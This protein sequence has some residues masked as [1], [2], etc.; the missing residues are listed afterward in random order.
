MAQDNKQDI[1]ERLNAVV[2][3]RPQSFSIDGRIFRLYPETLG[4]TLLIS[5][6]LKQLEIDLN[7]GILPEA[8]ALMLAASQP[9]EVC[10]IIALSCAKTKA[11][12][13][14]VAGLQATA[15]YFR[16]HLDTADIANLLL[17]IL[18]AER[19]ESLYDAAG[20]TED[21]HQRKRVSEAGGKGKNSISFGGCTIFGQLIDAACQRYGWTFDYVVWGIPL[22][23]LKLML[24]DG[25][26]TSYLSD[27]E[28]KKVHLPSEMGGFVDATTLSI[29]QLMNL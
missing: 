17:V 29:E 25:I 21:H 27:E 23:A 10:M 15:R 22:A 12:A 18:E 24:A 6:H 7:G 16:E 20:I 3:A 4:K 13:T 9:D 8:E 1:N 26:T 5:A 2:I 14:D 19:A 28:R 11:E